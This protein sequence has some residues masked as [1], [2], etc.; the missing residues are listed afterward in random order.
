[1]T[2]CAAAGVLVNAGRDTVDA[3]ALGAELDG[4]R[5]RELRDRGLRRAVGRQ[6][7]RGTLAQRC[8]D[9]HDGAERIACR[10]AQHG[11]R[12]EERRSQVE[13]NQLVPLRRG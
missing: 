9:V 10:A 5:A 2:W 4:Q 7:R 1:M 8:A 12:D 11:A 6:M 3:H 13:R